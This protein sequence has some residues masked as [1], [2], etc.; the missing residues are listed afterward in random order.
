MATT[1]PAQW[2]DDI[3][4]LLE[5]EKVS[6]G[7]NLVF[8]YIDTSENLSEDVT[9]LVDLFDSQGI[10]DVV[11]PDNS[12]ILLCAVKASTNNDKSIE[13]ANTVTARSRAAALDVAIR[14]T[15]LENTASG[16]FAAE[17]FKVK[18]GLGKIGNSSRSYIAQMTITSQFTV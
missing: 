12:I 15:I 8:P 9:V 10:K 2:V 14:Q 3:V 7:V 1:N 16:L 18:Y 17:S 11:S 4:A 6:L 5:S 13:M